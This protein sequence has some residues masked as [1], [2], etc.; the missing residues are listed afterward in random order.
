LQISC[1][2]SEEAKSQAKALERN[3]SKAEQ[4]IEEAREAGV[5][6]LFKKDFEKYADE[7]SAG[8]EAY[9]KGDAE[10]ANKAFKR[11]VKRV[12]KLIA[13]A[14]RAEEQ[15]KELKKLDEEVSEARRAAI[16]KKARTDA[17]QAF[18]AAEN[19][20]KKFRALLKDPEKIKS[21][22]RTGRRAKEAFDDAVSEAAQNVVVK[23]KAVQSKDAMAVWKQKAKEIG[24]AEKSAS[25][26]LHAERQERNGE[27]ELAN[28][29]F[30]E[31]QQSFEA[32]ET[33]FN[34]A[35]VNV[36]SLE[37]FAA[38][39]DDTNVPE[40]ADPESVAID[41]EEDSFAD[42]GTPEG[43]D[44]GSVGVDDVPT[45]ED[46]PFDPGSPE[47]FI[48][49]NLEKLGLG[50]DD[51]D[52]V[53]GQI[54]LDYTFG[55]DKF[56]KDYKA[57]KLKNRKYIGFWDP[58][59]RKEVAKGDPE[60]AISLAGN[61]EGLVLLPVPL[62]APM[63]IEW[64]TNIMVMDSTGS[65]GPVFGAQKG[66]KKYFWADFATFKR[67]VSGRTTKKDA[68]RVPKKFKRSANYW[69]DKTRQVRM[70]LEI[71][72]SEKKKGSVVISLFYDLDEEVGEKPI[73]I[74]VVKE[75]MVAGQ[76][77]WCWSRTKFIIRKLRVTAQLDKDEAVKILKEKLGVEDSGPETG[78]APTKKT[79]K[80]PESGGGDTAE[81]T[82][83]EEKV[84][85]ARPEPKT[86]GKPTGG[87]TK[88]PDD[89]DF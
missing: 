68:K 56:K 49:N 6:K 55:P 29:Q 17:P 38:G 73:N 12:P 30:H 9:E 35:F 36:K 26:W 40:V 77:G 3:R 80:T 74:K 15:A 65:M 34:S 16:A 39:N 88:E 62:K 63:T 58:G 20:Y 79:R 10:K 51:Y 86:G 43:S 8:E 87:T 78:S 85:E 71:E 4:A 75:T 11:I 31:A 42:S 18:A 32:A 19:N 54:I 67:F 7:F 33:S 5:S 89:F 66:G 82:D 41:P 72:K 22:E 24:A 69:F 48:E 21:A 23:Q 60:A 46:E 83:D 76:L 28:G 59:I 14:E 47:S 70:R 2:E 61:T 13:R 53:S 44:G 52:P 1:G 25:D 37:R 50:I 81:K 27:T 45:P 84:A 57:L 64:S